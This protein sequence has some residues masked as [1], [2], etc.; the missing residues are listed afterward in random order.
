MVAA[1]I[2]VTPFA[3]A[4]DSLVMCQQKNRAGPENQAV[5]FHWLNR[6]QH[7]YE[8][9]RQLLTRAQNKLGDDFRLFIHLTSLNHNLTNIAMQIAVEEFYRKHQRDPFTQLRAVT[10]PGR[11]NWPRFFSAMIEKH[12]RQAVEVYY[13]GPPPLA[14]ELHRHCRDFG[15]RFHREKFD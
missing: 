10:S 9:F 7:S 4:L 12:P 11:P 1:G 14:R 2:G 5:Y 13:C 15:F 8:W 6:S 3:S